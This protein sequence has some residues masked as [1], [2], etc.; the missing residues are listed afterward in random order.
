MM[1][2][3]SDRTR[4]FQRL[5]ESG[6][7]VVPNPWDLGSA[8][9]LAALGF[10]ALATTSSGFA[11]SQGRPDNHV[12]LAATLAFL[13]AMS[14][15][16]DIPVSAD[17]EGGF[18]TAPEDVGAPVAAA[19]TTGIAGLSIEDSTGD[20]AH[21]LFDFP[22][23]VARIQAARRA[24]DDSGTGV[25]LTARSEGFI[26][27]RPDLGE[28]IRRLTAFAEAGA[29]C[30]YAPGL[31][32]MTDI[33]AVVAAVA[34]KP[35]N[36]LVGGDFTT[37][38]QLARAGVRRISVGGALARVAWAG[39]LRAAREIAEQGTFSGLSRAMPF[40]EIDGFFRSDRSGATRD[41]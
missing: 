30:L 37:V 12:P 27:G 34:P 3:P 24:I 31:H 20:P 9:L 32:V 22:L 39:F 25:L 17:F 19:T 2:Q 16:V 28:T 21:P 1:A 33:S 18:A 40:A 15:A 36:V 14:D 7:F 38:E 10:S 29:D 23:A 13:R 11:W 8:R 4:A 35:V 41:R 26:V 6:C 5:H